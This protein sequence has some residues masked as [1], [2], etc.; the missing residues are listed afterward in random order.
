[1]AIIKKN[2]PRIHA[3]GS[4]PA[5]FRKEKIIFDIKPN[6]LLTLQELKNFI[7]SIP[8]KYDEYLITTFD[9]LKPNEF[10][11]QFPD[12]KYGRSFVH[13]LLFENWGFR[14]DNKFL[15]IYLY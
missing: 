3:V 1:M 15:N 9:P 10:T 7:N 5:Y 11:C 2:D 14:Q 4:G 13:H 8:E 6:E 12:E